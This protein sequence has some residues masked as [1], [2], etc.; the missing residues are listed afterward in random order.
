MT[1]TVPSTIN[2]AG[3]S[4]RVLRRLSACAFPRGLRNRFGKIGEQ[5]GEEQNDENEEIIK[6]IPLSV[7]EEGINGY[8]KHDHRGD[9]HGKHDRVPH[10]HSRMKLDQ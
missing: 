2:L 10:H 6:E 9:F 3:V 5:K 8:Q 7:A 1:V 4:S